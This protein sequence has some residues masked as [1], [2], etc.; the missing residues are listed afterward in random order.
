[1]TLVKDEKNTRLT[2]DDEGWIHTGDVG[3]FDECGRL[4]IIDRVKVR[5]L[6]SAKEILDNVNLIRTS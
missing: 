3:E 6:F 5:D 1:M 2:I 4:K